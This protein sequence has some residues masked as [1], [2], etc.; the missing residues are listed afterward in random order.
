MRG[1]TYITP[2]IAGELMQT[3]KKGH[4]GKV[5]NHKRLTDRQIEILKLL[6]EGHSAKEI[7]N[8]LHISPR[9]VETHKYK[10]MQ[11]LDHKTTADLIKYAIKQGIAFI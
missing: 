8:I 2:V 5:E 7:G 6:S 1:K 4:S 10:M 9:T 11:E 3:Y